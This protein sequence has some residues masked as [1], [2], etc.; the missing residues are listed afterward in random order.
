MRRIVDRMEGNHRLM[1]HGRVNPNQ[2]GD[3]ED[4][5]RAQ[6]ALGRLRLEDL[7]AV[8]TRW[9]RLLPDRRHR[10]PLH[11]E[12]A[13]AGRQGDLRAQGPAVR[14][15]V[16]R[17]QPVQRHRPDR[18]ALSRRE[19]PD[20]PLGLRRRA[21]KSAP[22]RECRRRRHRHADPLAARERHRAQQQRLRRARQHLALPDAR[23][24][25]GRACARQAVQV[26]RPRQ[27]PVGHGL[28]LVRLAAGPDPG[29][30]HL[31]DRAGVAR[32]LRLS[33][34]HARSCAQR[35]SA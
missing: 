23:P 10:H 16:L 30:P 9:A 29:V 15:A 34:D 32:A 35:C 28:D 5:E 12:G 27:R 7:H 21:S 31:P 20:L 2:P 1:I 8:G 3:V 25:A 18:E 24:G 19:L 33:R 4:M 11:R 6:G 13:R 14:P 26:L 17:A 22:R